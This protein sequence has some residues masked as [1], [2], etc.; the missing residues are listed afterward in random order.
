MKTASVKEIKN[1]LNNRSAQE[2]QILCL[3]LSKF[4]KENKELLTYLLFEAQDE[5][6]YIKEVKSLIEDQFSEI[7]TSS[8]YFIKKSVRK[9]LRNVKKY[10]RYS[11]KKETEIELLV[12]FCLTLKNAKPS[13]ESNTTLMNLY[14]RQVNIIHKGISALHEDQQFDYEQEIEALN[15]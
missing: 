3:Q 13:I 4:K 10:I 2:L 14:T 11:K 12:H 5:M 9:I 1:E 8:F 15:F 7:N 6:S